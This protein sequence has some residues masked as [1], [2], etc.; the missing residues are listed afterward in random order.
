MKKED[1]AAMNTEE[2]Q[3]KLKR[4]NFV[5]GLLAG[6]LLFSLVLNIFVNKKGI[7]SSV[8]VPLCLSPILLLVFN[9]IKDLKKELKSRV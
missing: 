8:V 6:A 1:Y 9:S 7:W 5:F 2:L 3:K 4:A